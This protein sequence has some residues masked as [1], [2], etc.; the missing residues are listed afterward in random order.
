MSWK[1]I[2]YEYVR[3]ANA[4]ETDFAIG[5][6][7]AASGIHEGLSQT[8]RN[9]LNRL[10]AWYDERGAKPLGSDTKLSLRYTKEGERET[11]VEIDMR[12][13]V[14]VRTKGIPHTEERVDRERVTLQ[15]HSGGE[16]FVKRAEPIVQ[17]FVPDRFG[18]GAGGLSGRAAFG[19]E[20]GLHS[21]PYLNERVVRTRPHPAGGGRAHV[22]DREAARAYA[23]RHWNRPNPQFIHFD[24]DCTNYVSQ[25]LYA[26][27]APMNYTGVR[28]SGW[29]YQGKSGGREMWSYSWSVAHAFHWHLM[30][31]RPGGG[32]G[33]EVVGEAG[34][35][36]VG[37]VICYDF[38][39]D[40]RFEHS[41]IVT[42]ADGA[43]MP[44][45]NAH[46]ANAR[47]RYWDYRDSY[48]WT[49]R[50]AYRF[51]RILDTF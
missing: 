6:I 15:R 50:T 40:G 4:R 49:N 21:A 44:L 26:G 30:K 22:Y 51:F 7:G 2:L 20:E 1:T 43:G 25:C 35:L 3:S 41:T 24:V 31:S 19:G 32:L 48:A 9:R 28:A 33:A 42:G 23:E 13:T 45:V 11:V 34:E 36:T 38:D 5:N 29:W 12:K 18:A 14:H 16:W 10:Q 8:E 39:G 46:T 27:G 17:E 47:A 37:D